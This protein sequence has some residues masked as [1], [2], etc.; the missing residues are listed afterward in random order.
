MFRASLLVE[1]LL[2]LFSIFF[3]QCGEYITASNTR[4][5][6][7]IAVLSLVVSQVLGAV[8]CHVIIDDKNDKKFKNS[9]G[10]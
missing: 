8:P 9:K 6:G 7:L 10:K 3:R 5:I 2:L 1:G 4:G